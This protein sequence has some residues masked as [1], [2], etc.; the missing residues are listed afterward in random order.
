MKRSLGSLHQAV[1]NGSV[2]ID[3]RSNDFILSASTL[4][5]RLL[6]GFSSNYPS[7]MSLGMSNLVIG[8]AVSNVNTLLHGT[9]Y[10]TQDAEFEK[11]L[12][13]SNIH[14][15]TVLGVGT[16][17]PNLDYLLH[18]NGDARIEGDLVVNGTVTSVN[19]NVSVTDQLSIT[20]DGTGPAIVANQTGAEPVAVLQDDG[21]PVFQV[22]DGGDV[23]I[24]SN[25][26][27]AKLDVQGNTYIRG[28]LNLSNI[29]CSNVDAS[30]AQVRSNLDVEHHLTV[31]NIHTTNIYVN[32]RFTVDS[33]GIIADASWIPNDIKFAATSV[34]LGASNLSQLTSNM[35]VGANM[36]GTTA[37]NSSTFVEST[38]DV[39]TT[40]V[41]M[42]SC[43]LNLTKYIYV[44]GHV[45]IG[46]SNPQYQNPDTRLRVSK[47][48]ITVTGPNDY[49]AP[50]DQARLYFGNSNH[51]IGGS[52]NVGIVMQVPGTVYPFVMEENSGYVGLGQMDPEER[53]HVGNHAKVA[54][55]LYVVNA[56][57]IAHSNPQETLSILGN[58]SL[59][60][61]GSKIIL[62]TSNHNLGVNTADATAKLHVLKDD[63]GDAFLVEDAVQD[64]TPFII[65]DD[66]R[67]GISTKTPTYRV[68]IHGDAR[69]KEFLYVDGG[70][71]TGGQVWLMDSNTIAEEG[72]GWRIDN[73]PISGCNCFRLTKYFGDGLAF[74]S[75][76]LIFTDYGWLNLTDHNTLPDERLHVTNGNAKF[77]GDVY[78][79]GYA[80]IGTSNPT[81][82]LDV[83]DNI[84]AGYNVYAMSGIGIGTSNV[85]H[86][87]EIVGDL[88]IVGNISI[89]GGSILATAGGAGVWVAEGDDIFY[90]LGSV[91][92][93]NNDFSE[94]FTVTGN[95]KF[96]Q[97]AYVMQ[98]LG[99]AHSNPTEALDVI[100]YAKASSGVR[101]GVALSRSWTYDAEY[102]SFV[103]SN[104][105]QIP[106]AYA[107]KQ[108]SNGTTYLNAGKQQSIRFQISNV[109][110]ATF[111]SNGYLGLKNMQ[112]SEVLHV[113]GNA[114]ITSNLYTNYRIAV[115]NS[116]PTER[117]DVTGNIKVSDHIY[118]MTA[119]SVA[120]SNPTEAVDI[121]GNAKISDQLY[122]L[123]RIGV[124]NSNPSEEIDVTGNT[125]ISS[126]LYTMYRIGVANSNPSEAVEVTGNEKITSNLY[127]LVRQAIAHSNPTEALDI[128]GNVKTSSNI[129]AMTALSVA[130]SNPTE[131][132]DVIG[133]SKISNNLYILNRTSIAHSNPTEQLDILGNSKISSNLYSMFSISIA[134]S[135][136]TEALDVIGN[137]KVSSNL[138]VM[139]RI[140]VRTSNPEEVSHIVG[141]MK[142]SSNMYTLSRQS[143][144]HSNPTEALDVMGNAKVS[145]YLYAMTGF[146]VATSNPTETVDIV[147]TTKISDNLYA[148]T[149]V[150]VANSNPT[151]AMDIVGNTKV[152]SRMYVMERFSVA[153]SNPTEQVDV[154][155]NAK[156]SSNMYVMQRLGVANSNPTEAVD[157]TGNAKV[158]LDMW[159]MDHVGVRT[160]NPTEVVDVI[161]NTKISSNLYAM[162][163]L[164]VATSNPSETLHVHGTAK[165][166]LNTYLMSGL[167]VGTSNLSETV[168]IHGT[169][170]VS[171]E[172]YVM[173]RM[174]IATSNLYEV[175]DVVGNAK[176]S[177]NIYAMNRLG[178]SDSN[179]T[180]ILHVQ[181]NAKMTSNAYAMVR[182]GVATSNPTEALHVI[183]N[184]KV[185]SNIYAMNRL[186][187][188]TSNPN[189]TLEVVGN[190]NFTGIMYNNGVEYPMS[191]WSSNYTTSNIYFTGGRVTIGSNS[192]DERF[193]V[194]YGNAKFGSNVYVLERLG[195]GTSNPQQSIDTTGNVR[196]V[197]GTLGPMIMLIPPIAFADISVGSRLALDN[198]VEAGNEASSSIYRSLF[199]T[200]DFLAQDLSTD[201]MQWHQARFIF[202]GMALTNL[203]PEDTIMAVQDFHWNRSPQYS[204]VTPNFTIRTNN[205]ERGYTT[206]ATPWFSCSTEDVRH[207]AI[208]VVSSTTINAVYRFGSVYMQFR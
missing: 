9:M 75:N 61:I 91:A 131:Q 206:N 4:S 181:G 188:N 115:A 38:I 6:F 30:N 86:A 126:N 143:I 62:S 74:E 193:N 13:A 105:E 145:Q 130:T 57:A 28:N 17:T 166:F 200:G 138:Y 118:A 146:G 77:D 34:Y 56:I 185:S 33:N 48:D 65:K 8:S 165:V 157:I 144:A 52:C 113:E 67:V 81:E 202:R 141:N 174:G 92:V 66:G 163:R 196:A 190:A 117:I 95:A 175:L 68:D 171:N 149:R 177:Q 16:L 121:T 71:E 64:T 89:Q 3:S 197:N 135:N 21:V 140:G 50:G 108:N 2:F 120:N 161:G 85:T 20:N 72:K 151:E 49:V 36:I 114:K 180:E 169:T 129:Y 7:S 42:T 201:Q 44:D 142:L 104:L 79:M 80:G 133:N 78:M 152:S 25:P 183:G 87:V 51:F 148:L 59:S 116:N 162:Q 207:L 41:N 94:A 24:G 54:S 195:V 83:V 5:Q 63:A 23:S 10:T 69:V 84:K 76:N 100:G 97:R 194:W 106:S 58:M 173:Q 156:I 154:T 98:R 204:N 164:G 119:L 147:G 99:V 60:N 103:H 15:Q 55:N 111:D 176:V 198:T 191:R 12:T 192:H 124:A 11:V 22:V 122:V 107:L 159:A 35:Q 170:K 53:L 31:P 139:D 208:R 123:D 39:R 189:Y 167:G 101:A 96:N 88:N 199:S 102:A 109:D 93:G 82:M 205:M 168:D 150:G 153:N 32:S 47:G 45:G 112:P 136:P 184:A 1:D 43:N 137:G 203:E 127:V 18:V 182:M 132:L 160:S 155:G 70:A 179:P 125:K 29:I 19:T 90:G 110:H 46:T 27:L 40:T 186:G 134:H 172:M 14:V 178:V 26:P 187:V 128:I 158:S 37:S 73:V